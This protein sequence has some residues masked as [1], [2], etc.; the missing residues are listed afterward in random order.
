M[1]EFIVPAAGSSKLAVSE[2]VLDYHFRDHSLVAE[3]NE[4]VF[5]YDKARDK[6][7]CQSVCI[8]MSLQR[9]SDR[10]ELCDRVRS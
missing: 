8:T 4:A 3:T 2:V 5:V 10:F 1:P 6:V 7:V 9:D